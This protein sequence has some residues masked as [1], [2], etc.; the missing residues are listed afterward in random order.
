[1]PFFEADAAPYAEV[2]IAEAP[3]EAAFEDCEV[4]ETAAANDEAAHKSHE[5][6]VVDIQP[7]N[8]SSTILHHGKA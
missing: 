8:P 6:I 3:E 5:A 2:S 4:F 1:M 7:Y